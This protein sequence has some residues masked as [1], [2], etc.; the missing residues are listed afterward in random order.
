M[1]VVF[2]QMQMHQRSI[3][4]IAVTCPNSNVTFKVPT[5]TVCRTVRVA[6]PICLLSPCHVRSYLVDLHVLYPSHPSIKI[7]PHAFYVSIPLLSHALSLPRRHRGAIE[8]P[9]VTIELHVAHG[10]RLAHLTPRLGRA[11]AYES[12]RTLQRFHALPGKNQESKSAGKKGE[13][14]TKSYTLKHDSTNNYEDL[15]CSLH[16]SCFS[17]LKELPWMTPELLRTSHS[18]FS[19]MIF[20]SQSFSLMARRC[21]KPPMRTYFDMEI[22]V[23]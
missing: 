13:C 6:S 15:N 18:W 14:I 19:T 22:S 7:V 1:Q 12:C 20:V 21:Q 23:Q 2:H 16:H 11:K 17:A 5:T 10:S 8:S 3:S 4:A 9:V